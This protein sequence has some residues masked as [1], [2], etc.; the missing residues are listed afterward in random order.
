MGECI[1][2]TTV[3]KDYLKL[4]DKDRL[5]EII[6]IEEDN[7]YLPDYLLREY[8]ELRFPLVKCKFKSYKNVRSKKK[9]RVK[10]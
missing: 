10:K 9:I 4:S 8:L 5:R 2:I 7:G 6:A 1:N 3:R